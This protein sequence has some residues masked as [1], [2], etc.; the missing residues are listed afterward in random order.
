MK[1]FL[2][3][4]ELIFTV[5]GLA[6][7]FGA[8]SLFTPAGTTPWRVAAFTAALVGVIH[9]LL[10]WLVRRRQREVR[11]KT[12]ADLQGMLQDIVNNQLSVIQAMN[13]LRQARPDEA[14]R[15]ADYTSRSVATISQALQHLSDESLVAW[16]NKYDHR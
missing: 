3:Q 16:K 7:I 8:A 10:F 12:I 1:F 14:Q 11:L 15:A 9:G 13:E 2:R 6:V 4:L 5:A